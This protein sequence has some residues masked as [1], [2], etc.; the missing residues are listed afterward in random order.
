LKGLKRD[1]RER[2][3]AVQSWQQ[4]KLTRCKSPDRVAEKSTITN[5]LA[6]IAICRLFLLHAVNMAETYIVPILYFWEILVESI[7]KLNYKIASSDINKS[8]LSCVQFVFAKLTEG[9]SLRATTQRDQATSAG[10]TRPTLIFHSIFSR[11]KL[12]GEDVQTHEKN[13]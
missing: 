7:N 4:L 11:L 13:F 3:V 12:K 5:L 8:G 2:K 10:R 9:C 6:H 1:Q